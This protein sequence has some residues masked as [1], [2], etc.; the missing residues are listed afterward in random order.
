[1]LILMHARVLN[2]EPLVLRGAEIA[3]TGKLADPQSLLCYHDNNSSD[4]QRFSIPRAF[5]NSLGR[6][7][8]GNSIMQLMFQ[9]ESNPFP[10]NYVQNYN[11]STEVASMEFRTENGTQIPI[12]GLDDSLAITVAINN[13][14]SGTEA[15][16]EG[17]GTGG[18][19]TAGTVNISYCDSVFVR[20]STG[21]TNRQAGVFVQLNFTSLRDDEEKEEREEDVEEPYITAY[22][23]SHEQP[24]EFN[25]TDS[26]RITLSM[27]RGQDLDHKKYTFFLSPELYDTTLDYF[28]N[29][30]TACSPSSRHVGVR[31]EVGVFA[32]LCQYF[33]ES[34]KQWRTDGMVPLAETNAS[35]AV[36]RTRHLTAFAAGLFV[37]SDAIS[38][39][40][41]ERTGAPSLVVLLV[42]VLGLLSYV[43]AAAI[44]HKL[45]QLDLRRA[46]VVPL[47]G[48]DG[49]FKYEIQVKTGWSRGAGTTAHVGISLYGRESRSGHR[50][51]DSRGAFTRNALDIFHIATDTSLGSVWKIRVWHD[52][53][54]LSPAWMLQYVLV[55]DLQTGSSYYFLA[56]EWLSVDNE[57]TDGRVEIEVEA[58]EEAVLR[59]LPRLLRCELQRSLCESHLW[60][61]LWERPHRS[62]FTRLQRATCCAVLL[63]FFLLA[64]TLWYSIV[65]DNRY[66][67][68]AVSRYASLNGETVAAGVVTCLIVYPLYLLVFTL[69]R[70]SRSKTNSEET[71]VDL[72]TPSTKSMESWGMAEEEMEDRD[73][74]DLLSDVSVVGGAGHGAGLPRLKRGQGSRHLGVDMTFNPDDEEGTDQRNKHFTSS[75]EDLIKHIL[76]DGQNFFPQADEIVTDVCRPRR[77]PPWCGRAALWGSWAGIALASSVSIWA[78]HGLSQN[79][80]MMWLISCFASFLCSCLLLEPIKVFCEAVYYV[81][82]VQ[83]LRPEDQDVLVEF[84]RVERVVQRV[85]RV[86]PPQGFALSQARHQARKVHMLHT[87]LK[88]FLVY[89]FFLLVVLLLNYSDSAKDT[90]GLRL[91][92]QLQQALHTPDYHNIS[93]RDDILVWLNESLLPRLLDDSALLRDTGSVLL[94]TLRLRQIHDTPGD[95]RTGDSIW[96]KGWVT[97]PV[98]GAENFTAFG[99]RD[100]NW[101]W[102]LGQVGVNNSRDVVHQLNRSLVEA[103]SSLQQLQQLH[104]LDYR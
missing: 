1:M 76:T 70:M 63:Q 92:T 12:S 59:Q 28:I 90:H 49:L 66:S 61:S 9:V 91:R 71:N 64:N 97:S 62:P 69:F 57:R 95:S 40:V 103:S 27:T 53:K 83:R 19:P 47:C 13:G 101:V 32:L 36:C 81:V 74:P 46:G 104:W 87:M 35:R 98:K 4:C 18:V 55:K 45:D 85:P 29:V 21:N 65:V 73:W 38:F 93:S 79:V 8:A 77:F 44:L 25:C 50:H 51:L 102:R 48:H 3:A 67:P 72:P 16:L 23:D 78:G 75:D 22:L 10:F 52:N 68:R 7:A 88:N 100:T 33:S 31:L 94:G 26:K 60:L 43:V 34:E 6:A 84:P 41:P 96:G 42:C 17:S 20:V 58:T 5:N 99:A 2:E 37:P 82:C 86:R 14:S 56:E 89:M 30:S 15:G 39:K 80:A 11:V 24:N 54:G